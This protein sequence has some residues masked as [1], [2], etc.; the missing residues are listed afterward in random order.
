MAINRTLVLL[1]A[2]FDIFV[3][4]VVQLELSP[5][6]VLKYLTTYMKKMLGLIRLQSDHFGSPILIGISQ[7]ILNLCPKYVRI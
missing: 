5:P 1:I 2:R 6:F 4:G 7:Q 3:L